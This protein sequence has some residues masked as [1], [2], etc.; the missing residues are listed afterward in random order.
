MEKPLVLLVDDNEATCTLI[1]ALL[2]R[3]FQLETASDGIEALERRASC[4]RS[5]KLLPPRLR[6]R[7]DR[8]R[9][10]AAREAHGNANRGKTTRGGVTRVRALRIDVASGADGR[11][12]IEI[13]KIVVGSGS[14]QTGR[15]L[16]AVRIAAHVA[17]THPS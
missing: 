6:E 15:D 13:R 12:R 14:A 11:A 10:A 16:H 3:D 17:D 4:H 5:W 9:S 7:K 2:Q 1:R 8:E